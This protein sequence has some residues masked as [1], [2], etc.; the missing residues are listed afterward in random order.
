MPSILLDPAFKGEVEI[1]DTVPP[2]DTE[3][4]WPRMI[5]LDEET[6]S[7]LIQ[8][9][10]HEIHLSYTERQTVVDDW[11]DWQKDYWAKPEQKEKNFPFRRAANIVIPVSAIAVEAVYARLLNTLF[12]VEPFWSIRPRSKD[13]IEAAPQVEKWLQNEVESALDVYGFCRESLLELVKLGTTVGKS[14]Y[15]RDVRKAVIQRGENQPEEVN[16]VEVYNGATLDHVPLANFL[17]RLHEKNPHD[18]AWVGE[19]HTFTWAQIKRMAASGQ[20]NKAAIEKIKAYWSQKTGNSE[21][22]AQ[23]YEEEMQ[24][25]ANFEPDWH[26]VF[27]T[28]EIWM[29]FDVDKDGYDEEIVVDFHYESGTIL[30][31]RY[32]WYEDLHRPYHICPY[33]PVEGRWCGIGI[34]KQSEQFQKLIT[35]LHRQRLDNA[36]LANMAQLAIKKTSGYGPNEPIFPGKIWFLDDVNDIKEVRLSEVY[37]SAYNNEEFARVYHEKRTGANEIVL[38]LPDQGTPATATS[39]LTRL[40]ESNKKF[41]AVLKN[42]RRWLGALG[43]DTLAN[44]QQFGDRDRHWIVFDPVGGAWVEMFLQM[45]PTLV[46]FGATVEVTVTDS[47]VNREVTR[48]QWMS[49]FAVL[50]QHYDKVLERAAMLGDPALFL[51]VGQAALAASDY[52]MR[53]LLETFREASI[54]IDALLLSPKLFGDQNVGLEQGAEGLAGGLQG[55]GLPPEMAA[56]GSLVGLGGAGANARGAGGSRRGNGVGPNQTTRRF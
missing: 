43:L 28:Q 11:I 53:R 32:N 34:G 48:Q 55:G 12:S 29:S 44:Y 18:A 46:R 41:D 16:Y 15:R 2:P 37:T 5:K 9:L 42:V 14:G 38:G 35:T 26:Q 47:I 56:F 17:L 27:N 39:D 22:P 13:W 50:T 25:L 10:Q 36:T 23:R 52:A 30:S 1:P 6:E 19:E 51:R 3:G 24:R 54:D 31:I 8:Y 20:F 45:P 49:L 40:A 4:Q 7:R 33:I 21:S